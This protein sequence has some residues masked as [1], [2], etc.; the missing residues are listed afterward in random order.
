VTA[1]VPLLLAA[2]GGA[3]RAQSIGATPYIANGNET[4]GWPE[5]G[6]FFTELGECSATL[7]GCRTAIT[8]AHCVC[9]ATGTGAS[10]GGGE[11]VVDPT[12]VAFF[13]PQAGFFSVSSIEIPPSYAFSQ[14][15]D[16]AVLELGTPLRSIRPRHINEL[17]RLPY[18]TFGTIV[19]YGLS[20]TTDFGIRREGTISTI[21]CTMPGG[22][23]DS[24]NICWNSSLPNSS[25]CEGDS[26]GPLLADVGA[27]LTLAGITTGGDE[28]TCQ[29][30]GYSFDTD[31]FVI[32]DWIRQQV[33]TELDALSCGDGPQLGDAA[34]SSLPLSGTVT[35]Q[36]VRTWGVPAGTK[37]LRVGLNG[38][39]AGD[40]DL[41]VGPG[42]TTSPAQAACSS[43]TSGSLEYCEVPD[44]TPGTWSALVTTAGGAVDYQLT[45]TMIPEDPAPPPLAPGWIVSTS[46]TSNELFEVDPGAGTRAVIASRL[47]GTGPDLDGPEG[48]ALD[49]DGTALVA[50]SQDQN[51]LRVDPTTGSRVVVSGCADAACSS[52]VGAGPAFF[53]PR[54]LAL[55]PDRAILVADR[56]NPGL[57]ALVR[58]DPATGNRSVVSGCADPACAVVVGGGAA[59]ARLFGVRFEASGSI[60]AVDGQALY[61]IDPASGDR[62]ILSG[63]VDAGC[64]GSVGNGPIDGQPADI[65]ID[66][67]GSIYVSYRIEGTPF[68]AVRRI[69]PVSGDRTQVSGCLDAACASTVGSGSPFVDAFGLAFDASRALLVGDGGLEAIVRVDPATGN[70]TSVS[71]CADPTCQSAVGTG[72][73]FGDALGV[74]RVPEPGTA[75]GAVALLGALALLARSRAPFGLP[76][77]RRSPQ[78][79][80]KVTS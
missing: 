70:R 1:L 12:S 29:V 4:I 14:Q 6:A 30:T 35:S 34:V 36:N 40:A 58:V 63:C 66:T 44:P 60:L 11:S 48:V 37:V 45:P 32:H 7:V 2:A 76:A 74:A 51:L 20:E 69:D 42:G 16:A 49:R 24:T 28:S 21:S 15:G 47:R 56:S 31:V 43:A 13:L 38:A 62:A 67:D 9:D 80:T 52:T 72:P 79:R 53:A 19:G 26:G 3:A 50:N 18:G 78:S 77:A 55:Y 33:G 73:G 22:V 10:C 59:I 64:S 25:T 8:A 68:G 61:R 65:A 71:G 17:A 27:G 5:V 57:Y 41:Y 46:F 54:F 75:P 39:G 23:P